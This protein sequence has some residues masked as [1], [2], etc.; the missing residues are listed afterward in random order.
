MKRKHDSQMG[1][2]AFANLSKGKIGRNSLILR[3]R[4]DVGE[5]HMR[6]VYDAIH[7]WMIAQKLIQEN[8]GQPPSREQIDAR[9]RMLNAPP[10]PA[11]E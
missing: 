3:F 2:F 11:Q 8:G 10:P 9:L 5:L 6:Q 7:A 4:E 1:L